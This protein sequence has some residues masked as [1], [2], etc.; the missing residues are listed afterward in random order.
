MSYQEAVH[1]ISLQ[2]PITE[3]ERRSDYVID[4]SGTIEHTYQQ[5]NTILGEIKHAISQ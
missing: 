1:R 5:L 3:K 2:M 4:N